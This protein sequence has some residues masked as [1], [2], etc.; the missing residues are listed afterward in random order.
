MSNVYV[1][2]CDI[3]TIMEYCNMKF[4]KKK[5]NN[6]P[7]IKVCGLTRVEEAIG[8]VAAGVNAIG[9]V[10]FPK[11]PRHVEDDNARVISNAL[12]ESIMRVGVF[13][14][15][16]YDVIMKKVAY[17]KLSAVQLHGNETP[18]LVLRLRQNSISVFKTLFVNKDPLISDVSTYDAS[19]Y[20]VECAGQK[21][22][23]GN[24]LS[25][26]FADVGTFS[27][28][29]PL[30]IAGGL[31]S[32]NVASAIANGRPDAVDVSSGVEAGPGKKDFQK[33]AKFIAAVTQF[34]KET[35]KENMY[36]SIFSN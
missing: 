6:Q 18:D 33:V 2:M 16:S 27:E 9:L 11:S 22:P 35:N 19:A 23:G 30:I 34:S 5:V 7:Q 1:Y 36:R 12:P 32:E 24:A 21:L 10:F 8:C 14:N 26:N 17:C 20:L 29:H 31:S 15:T 25:W 3:S 4:S 28:Q 13:V